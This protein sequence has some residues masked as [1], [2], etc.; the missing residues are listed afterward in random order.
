MKSLSVSAFIVRLL[1]SKIPKLLSEHSKFLWLRIGVQLNAF[2][3]FSLVI[4]AV[5]LVLDVN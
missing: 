1:N 5:L 3:I 4:I 2:D